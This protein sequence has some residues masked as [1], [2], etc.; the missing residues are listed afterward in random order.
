[1]KPSDLPPD[2]RSWYEER[3]AIVEDGCGCT[4]DE[5]ERRAL[6]MTVREMKR[7]EQPKVNLEMFK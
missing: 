7:V 5:A 2:W 4:R 3:A 1:M 6:E